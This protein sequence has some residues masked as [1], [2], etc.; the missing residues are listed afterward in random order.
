[1]TGFRRWGAQ[2]FV[3]VDGLGLLMVLLAAIV[4]PMAM[5]ASWKITGKKGAAVFFAWC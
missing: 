2:Y 4:V 5:L 3:G 1:M